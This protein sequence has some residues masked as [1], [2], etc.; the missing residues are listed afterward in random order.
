MKHC[1][2]GLG[3]LTYLLL[4]ISRCSLLC[5]PSIS[6]VIKY[7]GAIGTWLNVLLGRQAIVGLVCLWC[8]P[9]SRSDIVTLKWREVT[10][11]TVAVA[12]NLSHGW[13]DVALLR[14]SSESCVSWSGMLSNF[15]R[16]AYWDIVKNLIML[17]TKHTSYD[18]ILCLL[19]PWF[20]SSQP[21]F[22]SN[23]RRPS[24]SLLL[25]FN[26]NIQYVKWS[27]IYALF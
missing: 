23:A 14:D 13:W 17:S 3:M 6:A 4:A 8:S 25:D 7:F 16:A 1:L 21:R 10:N 18:K 26:C 15:N 22:Y 5:T 20:P 11:S 9:R 24:L 27:A 19:R 2:M 12:A